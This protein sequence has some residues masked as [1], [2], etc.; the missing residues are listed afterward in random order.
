MKT[1]FIRN[2]EIKMKPVALLEF[3]FD[4]QL[5]DL[6][7]TIPGSAWQPDLRAWAIPYSDE[8]ISQ[9]LPLFRGKAWLDY[10][11][12]KRVKVELKPA[13]I[14]LPELSE[15]LVGEIGKFS[16]WMRNLRYSE[17]TIKNYSQ[18][19]GLFFRF[20]GNKNPELITNED[21]ELFNK[22][23]IISNKYS[24]SFQSGV[25]NAVKLFF[26]NRLNRKLE[27]ALIER[28]KQPRILPH[29]LS[30]EEVKAILQAH[31]NIKHRAMLSLIYACGLRRSELLNLK[32]NDIDSKRGTVRIHRGKG[33]KDRVVPISEKILELLREYY[34][35]DYPKEYLFEGEKL[36]EKYSEGSIQKVLK[37][38]L[39]KA[40]IRKPV[41][42]HW[43]RHSYATHLLESGTDLR[44]IQELLGHNSSKT[45]EIYTH[46]SQKSLQKIKS[47]F[48]DL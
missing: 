28:P 30:K 13:P 31:Q 47:P 20:M 44:F 29:V 16:D 41:T 17:S 39:V 19:I 23:Y 10:T 32:I 48:D 33:A 14:S 2:A 22:D 46:V 34:K 37:S 35:Y 1:I 43:L 4:Q 5:I 40:K 15:K 3:P 26:S 38:A 9:L 8:L 18:G 24:A 12:F 21:L 7:R 42:L 11:E 25:I 36:G 45:T 6:V 27:P